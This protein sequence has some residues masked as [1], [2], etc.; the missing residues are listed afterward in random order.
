MAFVER[1]NLDPASVTV[2]KGDR[3]T[4]AA[5]LDNFAAGMR[6]CA[7]GAAQALCFTPFNKR[8]MRMV[9]ALYVD[10]IGFIQRTLGTDVEGAEFNVPDEICTARVTSHLPLSE[11]EVAA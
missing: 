3:T 6:V 2:G 11:V 8:A 9:D 4:G 10:E 1:G 5:A 7:A